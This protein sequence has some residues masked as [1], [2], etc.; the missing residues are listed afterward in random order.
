MHDILL[1]AAPGYVV[2]LPD[3]TP[4]ASAG[5]A[6]K[7]WQKAETWGQRHLTPPVSTRS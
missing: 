5:S 3:G 1:S 7:T 2:S 6:Q 4:I